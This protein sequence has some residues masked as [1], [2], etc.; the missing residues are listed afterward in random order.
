M[1]ADRLAHDVQ[2]ESD[3]FLIQYE[4]DL[5]AYMLSITNTPNYGDAVLQY[6]IVIHYIV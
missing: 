1:S 6:C 3:Q 2:P 4:Q 5:V